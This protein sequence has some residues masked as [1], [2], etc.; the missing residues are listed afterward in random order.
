MSGEKP[1]K[2]HKSINN[3]YPH[4]RRLSGQNVDNYVNKPKKNNNQ[5]TQKVGKY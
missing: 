1:K 5:N 4:C 3:D 2:S